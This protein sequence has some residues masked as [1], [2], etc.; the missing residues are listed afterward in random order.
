VTL[1]TIIDP[2]L[3]AALLAEGLER[4]KQRARLEHRLAALEELH[5][6]LIEA[7]ALDE[8]NQQRAEASNLPKA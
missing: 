3:Q 8:I 5:D 4:F 2:N 6:H 7:A 1:S